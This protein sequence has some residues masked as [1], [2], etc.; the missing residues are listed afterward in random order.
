MKKA[1]ASALV[2]ATLLAA[3][4][5]M[6]A[7]KKKDRTT[8]DL[9]AIKAD[10]VAP[11]ANHQKMVA[12]GV[13]VHGGELGPWRC[14]VKVL[15]RREQVEKMRTSGKVDGLP[16]SHFLTLSVM[17]PASGKA[18]KAGEGSVSVTGPDKQ[19]LKAQLVPLDGPFTADLQMAK[20]GEYAIRIDFASAKKKAS[21][22]FVYTVK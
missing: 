16:A 6:A 12:M 5:A 11:N 3:G 13:R 17:D 8:I 15:D 9:E 2:L 4:A 20:P 22:K 18:L 19:S 10:N 7:D 21:T 1:T 14:Q